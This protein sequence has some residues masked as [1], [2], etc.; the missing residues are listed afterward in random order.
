MN[1][2]YDCIYLY[3]Q[4][5]TV[6]TP[7]LSMKKWKICDFKILITTSAAQQTEFMNETRFWNFWLDS[8]LFNKVILLCKATIVPKKIFSI[9]LFYYY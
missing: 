6:R 1:L 7:S 2:D 3:T 5:F 4:K 8:I 9:N